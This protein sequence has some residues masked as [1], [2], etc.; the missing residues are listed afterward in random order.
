MI[1]TE[2]KTVLRGTW[3]AQSVEHLSLDFSSGHDCMVLRWSPA[4]GL[5][6]SLSVPPPLAQALSHSLSK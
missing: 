5:S 1:N 4:S 6:L 3:V 2:F